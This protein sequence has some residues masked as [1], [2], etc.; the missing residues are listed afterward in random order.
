MPRITSIERSSLMGDLDGETTA[1][2]SA[3]HS[4]QKIGG[5]YWRLELRTKAGARLGYVHC[6]SREALEKLAGD[7]AVDIR[8]PIERVDWLG[9]KE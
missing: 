6:R 7:L 4:S 3:V 2:G 1:G 9:V 5:E 8:G